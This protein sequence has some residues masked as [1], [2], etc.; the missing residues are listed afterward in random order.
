METRGEAMSAAPDIDAQLAECRA[1]LTRPGFRCRTDAERKASFR[2]DFL[3]AF[4]GEPI[5][6]PP[7]SPESVA[8]LAELLA[9]L[10]RLEAEA[11]ELRK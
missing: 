11:L 1:I 9:D 7:P 3:E 2:R 8:S 10:R 5:P 4:T 6:E